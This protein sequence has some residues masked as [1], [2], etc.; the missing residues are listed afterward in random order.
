MILKNYTYLYSITKMVIASILTP[1]VM[2][3]QIDIVD[4]ELIGSRM[5]AK[6]IQILKWLIELGYQDQIRVATSIWRYD[7]A[8]ATETYDE[9]LGVLEDLYDIEANRR[10]SNTTKRVLKLPNNEIQSNGFLSN[11]KNKTPK[12]GKARKGIKKDVQINLFEEAT[13]FANAKQI[14]MIQQATGGAKIIINIYIANPWVLSNWYV[15]R[16]NRFLQFNEKRLREDGEQLKQK[17][18]TETKKLRISHITNH[19][20]NTYL[21]QAQHQMLYDAWNISDQFARVVD[22]G[23]PGVAEGLVYA[24][25]IHKIMPT[26]NT[27]P[28]EEFR[29]GIDWGTSTTAGG[30][31]TTM[32]LGRFGRDYSQIALDEEY[33]HSN[34]KQHYKDDDLLVS[35]LIEQLLRYTKQNY[36]KIRESKTGH[37]KVF[38]DFGAAMLGSA[39]K[40]ELAKYT[41]ERPIADLILIKPCSKFEVPTRIDIVKHLISQGRYKV[42]KEKMPNHME[43]LE[44]SQWEETKL[45]SGR[46]TRLNEDDHTLDA[47]EYM[48]GDK[49]LKFAKADYLT[50]NKVLTTNYATGKSI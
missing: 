26:V 25:I 9:L 35:E 24:P 15:K 37:I 31:A 23:M 19:R 10:N 48:I 18:F 28:I 14:Q 50:L 4:I 6:T 1:N 30:S 41:R 39:L 11:R 47:M 32:V 46:P 7:V 27:M 34:A 36:E 49:L 17:Y 22:L 2:A 43:E 21:S 45:V 40:K 29:G 16:V 20:I 8:G 5:S 13:E 42:N 44:T 33:Y 38:Y 3:K 12:L